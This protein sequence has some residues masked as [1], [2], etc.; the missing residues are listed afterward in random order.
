MEF[1]QN[2]MVTAGDHV[3]QVSSVPG[4][5]Q[6]ASIEE[7]GEEVV[8]RTANV[9]ITKEEETISYELKISEG[10]LTDE[11]DM[12]ESM[13]KVCGNKAIEKITVKST[14][15][16]SF[17][18]MANGEIVAIEASNSGRTRR[19]TECSNLK[20]TFFTCC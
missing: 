3:C 19:D 9:T 13:K 6:T 11:G 15:A 7:T 20:V 16:D 10:E 1:L 5:I 8:N 17:N 12:T 14:D 4:D 18:K 2:T